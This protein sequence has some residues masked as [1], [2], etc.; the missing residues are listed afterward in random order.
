MQYLKIK[1][2]NKKIKLG[3]I[4]CFGR[5]YYEHAKE[6]NSEIYEFPVFFLKP[7]SSLI[8]NGENIILPKISKDVQHEVELAFIISKKCKNVKKENALNYVL[9]YA[10]FNDITARDLQNFAK[11]KALPW[12]LSKG[13]DTFAPISEITLKQ[14]VKNPNNLKISLKVNNELRQNSNT[15]Y[16][17]FKIENLI[18][19][20]SS[21]M[22]LEK[23]DVIATGTP[24]GVGKIKKGD[25]IVC[26]IEWLGKIENGVR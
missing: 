8:G 14:E 22:T 16:M 26:E 9:G 23:G 1:T 7:N 20:L 24:K 19:Y 17:V 3:K 11:E 12:T 21:V 25:K 2:Q 10:I 6:L 18:E 4:I 5:N 13:F 15:K